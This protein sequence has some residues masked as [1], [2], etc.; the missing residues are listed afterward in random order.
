MYASFS[1]LN[2][3]NDQAQEILVKNWPYYHIRVD[4]QVI[5][6]I[7]RGKKPRLPEDFDDHN[8]QFQDIWYIC[9]MC[10]IDDNTVRWSMPEVVHFLNKALEMRTSLNLSNAQ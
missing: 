3:I 8:R 7:A 9:N 6:M 4:V 10:W 5:F 2:M 1:G